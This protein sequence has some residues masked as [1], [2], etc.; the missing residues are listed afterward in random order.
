MVKRLSS[1]IELLIGILHFTHTY[2]LYLVIN[3]LLFAFNRVKFDQ[4][5]GMYFYETLFK[6]QEDSDVSIQALGKVWNLHKLILKQVSFIAVTTLESKVPKM[7][8]I[9]YFILEDFTSNG[10]V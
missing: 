8:N 1:K 3:L 4:G 9:K 7:C 6:N 2:G 10:K 5:N